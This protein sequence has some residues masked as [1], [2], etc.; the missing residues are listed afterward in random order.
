M[1]KCEH[2]NDPLHCWPCK[3]Y[4]DAEQFG[5]PW[6]GEV[7]TEKKKK[8]PT[9]IDMLDYDQECVDCD[10]ELDKEIM[11]EYVKRSFTTQVGDDDDS[12]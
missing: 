12:Q 8:G 10:E 1:E 2:G 9:R 11:A 4:R 3:I 6:S 5:E 7:S